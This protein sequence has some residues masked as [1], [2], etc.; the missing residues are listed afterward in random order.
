MD[1]GAF[2]PFSL[3]PA[4]CPGKSLAMIELR[5]MTCLL[6]RTFDMSFSDGYDVGEWERALVDRF[7]TLKGA[8]PLK[9][10]VRRS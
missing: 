9:L 4:G 5:Y 6:V 7:V 10:S 3:G 1:R 8:L 2:I